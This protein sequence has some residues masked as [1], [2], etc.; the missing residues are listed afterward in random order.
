MDK[1]TETLLDAATSLF[2]NKVVK[3]GKVITKTTGVATAA[4]IVIGNT[5]TSLATQGTLANLA[6]AGFTALP[7][8]LGGVT[9]IGTA[10]AAT[11]TVSALT[12]VASIATPLGW[13]IGGAWS[14]YRIYQIC[15]K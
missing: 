10:V 6:S 2:D 4:S 5:A 3:S 9:P 11:G 14:A 1:N 7:T 12:A 15:K 8:L 13:V